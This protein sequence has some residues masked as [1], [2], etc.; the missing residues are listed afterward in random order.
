[1][2]TT[3]GDLRFT[4]DE[5]AKIDVPDADYLHYGAWIKKTTDADGVVEY[6]EVQT[7]A[8][9]SLGA[10]DTDI[11][12]AGGTTL[13]GSATYDGDAAGVY[14]HKTLNPDG[15]AS[16]V[17]SGTFT[18]DAELMAN[19]GGG[20]VA[21]NNQFTIGGSISNFMLSGGEANSWM[22]KLGLADF[23]GRED[24]NAPGESAPGNTYANMF[25]GMTDG[26][27]KEAPWDGTFHGGAAVDGD[28]PAQ[29]PSV[30]TGE[31]N[32]H[33]T[34]GHVAGAFGANI[35]K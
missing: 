19:F 34:N 31:F 1:M 10:T 15:T 13:E 12:G 2:T 24:G 17:G 3:T 32:A 30:V 33:M 29:M 14:A 11:I 9:S 25:S 7:F 22:V 18:A 21:A 5:G 23:S 20:E 27:G 26:G 6:N 16:K 28:N 4:P 8:D 35:E